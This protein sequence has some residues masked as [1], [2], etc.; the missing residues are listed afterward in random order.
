MEFV[1]EILKHEFGIPRIGSSVLNEKE[2]EYLSLVNSQPKDAN[3]A[4]KSAV[5]LE[6]DTI[7]DATLY[8]LIEARDELSDEL[9]LKSQS[10]SNLRK[11]VNDLNGQNSQLHDSNS[12]LVEQITN[13]MGIL[14]QQQQNAFTE[15]QLIEYKQLENELNESKSKSAVLKEFMTMLIFASGV[16]WT[17]DVS[18]LDIVMKKNSTEDDNDLM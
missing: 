5:L 4:I 18:L 16:D 12:Q 2:R 11:Q 10:I 7:R 15:E 13:K 9:Q 17:E 8:K 1:R 14:K 3:R 6:N